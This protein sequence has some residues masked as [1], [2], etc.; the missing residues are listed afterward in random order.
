MI[1]MLILL[2]CEQFPAVACIWA[3]KAC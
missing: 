3:I 1:P 2:P